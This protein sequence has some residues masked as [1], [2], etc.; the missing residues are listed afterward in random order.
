VVVLVDQLVYKQKQSISTAVHL[1]AVGMMM[2]YRVDKIVVD[3]KLSR[4][5]AKA[6]KRYVFILKNKRWCNFCDYQVKRN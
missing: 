3:G 2:T 5:V 4:L 1:L 6:S